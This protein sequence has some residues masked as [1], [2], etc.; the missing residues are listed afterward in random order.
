MIDS[1]SDCFIG[2]AKNASEGTY[3]EK[4]DD[5]Q[6]RINRQKVIKNRINLIVI[7]HK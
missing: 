3:K 4:Q 2:I 5:N 7:V 6:A 1:I